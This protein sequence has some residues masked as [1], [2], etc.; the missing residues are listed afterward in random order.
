M[1]EGGSWLGG[2]SRSK[3]DIALE[4]RTQWEECIKLT[5]PV[6]TRFSSSLLRLLRC[7]SHHL[8]RDFKI[9]FWPCMFI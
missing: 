4:A 1:S 2:E 5:T 9:G 7:L 8:L 3:V 6:I